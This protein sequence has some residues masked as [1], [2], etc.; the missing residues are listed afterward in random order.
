M[1]ITTLAYLFRG[2]KMLLGM[3]RRSFGVGKWN[4]YGGKLEEDESPLDAVIR[5]VREECSVIANKDECTELGYIDFFFDDKEEWNQRVI[6]YRIDKFLGE[7]VE[8]EEMI[9]AWF[10]VSKLPYEKMWTSDKIWL[11]KVVKRETFTGEIHLG[12]TGE[13]LI[14]YDIK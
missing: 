9:P 8:T 3:K 1:K 2:D 14:R 6:V 4:G 7:P 13:K 11:P 10:E 5:E 12:N